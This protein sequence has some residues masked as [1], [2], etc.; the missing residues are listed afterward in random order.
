MNPPV[1][2]VDQPDAAPTRKVAAGGV[3]GAL[4]AVLAW[5]AQA[6]A[7]VTLPPGMEGAFVVIISFAIAYFTR[8]KAQPLSIIPM[9][10]TNVR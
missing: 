9:G 7:G 10:S 4:A 8:D 3:A 6:F 1:V 5:A 2:L